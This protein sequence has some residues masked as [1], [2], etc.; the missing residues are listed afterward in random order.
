MFKIAAIVWIVASST[1][2]GIALLIVVTVP[3]LNDQAARLIPILCGA[4]AI[5]AIPISYFVAR[6]VAGALST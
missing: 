5:A 3:S 1:L 6:H 2:A 4:A